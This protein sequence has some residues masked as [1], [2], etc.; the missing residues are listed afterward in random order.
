LSEKNRGR[1]VEVSIDGKNMGQAMA[2]GMEVRV[3]D[4]EIRHG[5]NDWRGGV[6]CV[7]RRTTGVEEADDGW[8]GGLNSLLKFNF[9]F[10]ER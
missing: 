3:W 10:G 9:P 5:K 2:V 4:E 6:P 1:E 8:V 7:M